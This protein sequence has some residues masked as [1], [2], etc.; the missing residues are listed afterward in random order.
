MDDLETK[1][2]RE[3][4]IGGVY[5]NVKGFTYIALGLYSVQKAAQE[6][7][8]VKTPFGVAI[9]SSALSIGEAVVYC[10]T[11]NREARY[12]RGLDNFLAII[13]DFDEGTMYYRFELLSDGQQN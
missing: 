9:A 4:V 13:G 7:Q 2:E 5:R 1:V 8:I 6:H 11:L 12:V 10:S 3:L